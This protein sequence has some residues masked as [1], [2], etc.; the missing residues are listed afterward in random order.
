MKINS[1]Y[2]AALIMFSVTAFGFE[3]TFELQGIS[4]NVSSANNSSINTLTI[5]PSG[6]EI[7]NSSMEIENDLH[8]VQ[9][10]FR[11]PHRGS[12][13]RGSVTPRL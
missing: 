7:D 9:F 1:I 2:L 13:S 3:E 6:L 5:Q 8:K 12:V 10:P 4:F 11:V